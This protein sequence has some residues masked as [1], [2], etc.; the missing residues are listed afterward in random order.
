MNTNMNVHGHRNNRNGHARSGRSSSINQYNR[1]IYTPPAAAILSTNAS[2]NTNMNTNA[3]A[4]AN[5]NDSSNSNRNNNSNSGTRILR[6]QKRRRRQRQRQREDDYDR[7]IINNSWRS[8]YDD[9]NGIDIDMDIDID[10]HNDDVNDNNNHSKHNKFKYTRTTEIIKGRTLRLNISS[11]KKDKKKK[12]ETNANTTANGSTTFN[13]NTN[14]KAKRKIEKQ[15]NNN[16]KDKDKDKPDDNTKTKAPKEVVTK[17]PKDFVNGGGGK[18]GGGDKNKTTRS[19]APSSKPS[20]RPTPAPSP[21]P[22]MNPTYNPTTTAP[23]IMKG[24]PTP[25]PTF[26]VNSWVGDDIVLSLSTMTADED[27]LEFTTDATDASLGGSRDRG[28]KRGLLSSSLSLSSLLLSNGSDLDSEEIMIRSESERVL[29]RI[30]AKDVLRGDENEFVQLILTS[31]ADTLCKHTNFVILAKDNVNVNVSTDEYTDYCKNDGVIID[32][33]SYYTNRET[34]IIAPIDATNKNDFSKVD[35]NEFQVFEGSIEGKYLHWIQWDVKCTIVQISRTTLNEEGKDLDAAIDRVKAEARLVMDTVT[36]TDEMSDILMNKNEDILS[37]SASGWEVVE[38]IEFMKLRKENQNGGGGKGGNNDDD[39]NSLVGTDDDLAKKRYNIFQP[40]RVAGMIMMVFFFVVLTG[41]IKAGKRRDD[42]AWDA[43]ILAESPMNGDLV[44]Y[45]G[46]NFLLQSSRMEAENMNI[47]H[48]SPSSMVE[49]RSSPTKLRQ[50]RHDRQ[51][52][53]NNEK[54]T[55]SSPP[56]QSSSTSDSGNNSSSFQDG[57]NGGG[58]EELVT[59]Q[60]K[61]SILKRKKSSVTRLCVSPTEIEVEAPLNSDL[62]TKQD[63]ALLPSSLPTTSDEVKNPNNVPWNTKRAE[64][65]AKMG[66]N[67][68]VNRQM[69]IPVST[70]NEAPFDEENHLPPSFTA[71]MKF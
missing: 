31:L 41:L 40:I 56:G 57:F 51:Y 62:F 66:K 46:V 12:R 33:N 54:K 34:V 5:A 6:R 47:Q 69:E 17:G 16:D 53:H 9:D 38:S 65:K 30:Y 48:L 52:H 22:T 4:N 44:S 8:Y 7:D 21:R 14:T 27:Q 42:K 1:N 19:P 39:V 45:E 36:T 58:V 60:K 15:F 23:T 18:Q 20:A 59:I 10:I 11:K 61:T 68:H 43:R 63:K 64:H 13:V 2:E 35:A 49:Q 71:W 28:R 37:V 67:T 24:N 55:K 70:S 26:W 32:P 25:G 3:N 50:D 29:K